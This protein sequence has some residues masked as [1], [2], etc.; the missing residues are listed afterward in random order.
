MFLR[1]VVA[2][3]LL[4]VSAFA[5][6]S[7]L[8]WTGN[9]DSISDFAHVLEVIQ[10]KTGYTFNENDFGLY[11]DRELATSRFKMFLQKAA[12]VPVDG[13]SVRIWSDLGNSSVIQV[14]AFVESPESINELQALYKNNR[15]N[16]STRSLGSKKIL[17][18]VRWTVS[19]I[20]DDA[21]VFS[22][23]SRDSWLNGQL[24]R[25]VKAKGRRGYHI[26]VVSVETHKVV[27][28]RY[29]EFPNSDE[30]AKEEVSIPVNIYPVYEEVESTGSI[31]SRVASELKYIKK[32]IPKVEGDPYAPLKQQRYFENMYDPIL[33]ETEEGRAQGYWAI[34]Y[35]KREASRIKSA[36]PL[37]ENSF[38]NGLVLEGRYA[39]V[40]MHPAAISV[41]KEIEFIP[42]LS[43]IFK[44]DWRITSVDGQNVWEMVPTGSYLGRPLFSNGEAL[45][46]PARRLADHNPVTYINDG[47]D[48]IQVYYA[49]TK[50]FDSLRPMG[51]QDPE[52]STRPFHAFLYDPDISMQDNAYY[53]DD[54]INFT[55]YSPKAIN[56]ARD[57]STVW[58]ELGHGIMDRMMGDLL[59]LADTGGLSEGIADLLA[60]L[61]V[62]DVTEGKPFEGSDAFRIINKIGFF[63][64]NEVH[65]DG[66]AY[67]GAMND[68]LVAAVSK[69]GRAGLTKVTDTILEGMRLCRNHPR[70]TAQEWFSHLLFADQLGREG[71]RAP[72][73]LSLLILDALANRNFSMSNE[74]AAAFVLKNQNNEITSDSLGSR[75]MPIGVLLTED[76]TVSF[77][78][79]ASVKNGQVYQFKFPV[80]V[81]VSFNNGPLQGAVHWVGEED[82]EKSYSLQS[83]SDLANFSLTVSGK[84]DYPNRDDG[85]C[86]DFTYVQIWNSDETQ[87]PQAKKRFYVRVTPITSETAR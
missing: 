32:F 44:P 52:L 82:G 69:Y 42:S 2:I 18:I 81:K 75:S 6:P 29:E 85:S 57:N 10:K 46:R 63:L 38:Q 50:L 27:E 86:V 34:S 25:T 13:A 72:G 1:L 23:T 19:Q 4:E 14:E 67:G 17:D 7:Y 66:E 39:T 45:T 37:V 8:R 74:Q 11:E 31:Q 70:L 40:S 78:M 77:S 87:K 30:I 36:L 58:H 60:Q 5:A 61:V 64:T 68:L 48:E 24:V 51:F 65:D 71:I 43:T 55:T 28:Y 80:T 3:L 56:Y 47:F 33:G 79:N 59:H 83:E 12:G 21:N 54:T 35:I 62:Q 73:E 49:I 16:K 76:Q 84:C 26:I 15:L 9:E 41:F 53:T 22:V 20:S